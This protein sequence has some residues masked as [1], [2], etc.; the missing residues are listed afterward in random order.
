MQELLEM[1]CAKT[2][3]SLY[4]AWWLV[5]HATQQKRTELMFLKESQLRPEQKEALYTMIDDMVIRKKPLAYILGVIPF[6]NVSIKVKPPILIPRPETEEWVSNVISMLDSYGLQ[7]GKI[8]DMCT[9]TGCIALAFAKYFPKTKVV[10]ADINQEAV[11]LTFENTCFNRIPNIY[12]STTNLF[13]ELTGLTFD[14]IVSNPPYI[15]RRKKLSMKKNVL[16]WE[17]EKAL[18]ANDHGMALIKDIIDYAPYYMH[19][20][21]YKYNL[22]IEIAEY[23]EEPLKEFLQEQGIT[24]YEFHVDHFGNVRMLAMKIKS[25]FTVEQIQASKQP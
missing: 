7:E 14:I 17:D 11:D 24:Q 15:D 18:F 12:L 25:F 16:L 4:Q 19:D 9:G 8:L 6:F 3:I 13:S 23:H 5:E 2:G 21:P 22:F 20:T 1:I 10:A